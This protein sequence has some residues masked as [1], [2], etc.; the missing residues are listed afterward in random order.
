MSQNETRTFTQEQSQAM[1]AFIQRMGSAGFPATRWNMQ[2]IREEANTLLQTLDSAPATEPA[3]EQGS[4][5]RYVVREL[6]PIQLRGTEI[7]R[8]GVWDET[9]KTWWHSV[10]CTE[11]VAQAKADKANAADNLNAANGEGA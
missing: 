9:D 6:S 5:K 10:P 3:S 4:G 2:Q 8:Y 1:Y 11:E 7:G